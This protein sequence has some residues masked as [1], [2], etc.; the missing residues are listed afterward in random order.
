MEPFDW[1]LQE[2]NKEASLKPS[3]YALQYDIN[4]SKVQRAF[5]PLTEHFRKRALGDV[6]RTVPE[7]GD[8]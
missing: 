1:T 2:T 8:W 4:Q 3:K 7:F 5:I 6:Y